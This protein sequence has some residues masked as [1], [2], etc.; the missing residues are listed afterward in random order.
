MA[1]TF[2]AGLFTAHRDVVALPGPSG[3]EPGIVTMD[4]AHRAFAASL[5]EVGDVLHQVCG[6]VQGDDASIMGSSLNELPPWFSHHAATTDAALASH[7]RQTDSGARAI[8]AD[9][10]R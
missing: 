7:I 8:A 3:Y 5:N 9:T 1:A 4:D 2:R 6:R 10:I